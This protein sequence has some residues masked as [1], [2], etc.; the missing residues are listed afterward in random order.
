MIRFAVAALS[1]FAYVLAFLMPMPVTPA[2]AMPAGQPMMAGIHMT[3]MTADRTSPCPDGEQA[4]NAAAGTAPHAA[5]TGMTPEKLSPDLCRTVCAAHAPAL[6]ALTLGAPLPWGPAPA[7]AAR[8]HRR[9]IAALAAPDPRPPRH[10]SFI[11]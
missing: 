7:P 11:L 6:P 1:A 8:P 9:L 5:Q 2:M 10:I 4:S 3:D